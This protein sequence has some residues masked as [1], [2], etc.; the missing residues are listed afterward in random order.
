MRNRFFLLFFFF[1][2]REL[3]KFCEKCNRIGAPQVFG[4]CPSKAILKGENYFPIS[5]G[6]HDFV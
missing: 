6:A 1:F 2:F 5:L 4:Q 3:A